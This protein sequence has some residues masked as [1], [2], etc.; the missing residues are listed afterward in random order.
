MDSFAAL[1]PDPLYPEKES[2]RHANKLEA[3][4][5]GVLRWLSRKRRQPLW[6]TR[7]ILAR[8]HR[9]AA[10]LAGLDLAGVR[11]QA[12]EVAFDLRCHGITPAS[13][14]RAFALVRQAGRLAL[15][16]AHFDVQLLG[17]WAMLQGMVAEM[18]TGEGKTLTATLPAATAALA[19]LPV[20]VITTND[21]LVER[22]AEIMAPLYEA[23]GLSVA[24][25]SMEM[26]PQARRDAYQADIVYCSNK[27]LV[28][29]YLRD[30]IVLDDD[31]DED[32]LR[33]ERLRG[34]DGR[35]RQL[36][37]RGLCFAIVDEADSV[38]VDEARTPLIISGVQE[39]DGSAVTAQAMALAAAMQAPHYR[40]QPAERRAVLTE[41]GREYLRQACAALPAPWSIPFR[42][43]ELI[44]SALTVLHLYKRDEQYIVRDGKVMVVD[45]FTGRVMP[46]RSWGQ[47]VHQMIEH[48]EGLE[49]SDPRATLKSI[50]YQRFF[51]HY[52]LLAG[53]TGTAA[54]IRAELGRVYNLPVVRIPT[55]RK[56]RRLHAPD[57]VHRTMADKWAAVR[58][59]CRELHARG[60]P[61]LIGTRSVAASEE[62]A[63]VLAEARLPAVVLN[64]KQDA[65]EAALIARAGEIGSI[66][67]ATN[68]AGRGTDIPLSEAARAAGGLH[69]ILTERHES[70]RIDRQ[71]EGRSGRQGDPG[72]AEAI[73]SLEDAVLDSVKDSLWARPVGAL[74]AAQGPGWRRLAAHWLRHA[75]ARTE[76]KLARERRQMVAA[77]EELENSLSFSGQGD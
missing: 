54:E 11:A 68:M 5:T 66:M 40:I 20:H 25:V 72:H 36:F 30:L 57:S 53:M 65:D 50:S 2:E 46:D 6:R 48:K 26:S 23:L 28:F 32:R 43:E 42:R 49:L 19:G 59:R 34:A 8:V 44:L 15:G 47:G 10:R 12:D 51:K 41:A 60:V 17:G 39:E 9:E 64:A 73:L 29:D 56:S 4:G 18:N 24:W 74:L 76:R 38:L 52:L 63:R 35:L 61:V 14:A 62:V 71:L 21:Y 13:A 67:I 37:L 58:E 45:E 70:A 75:Q 69:V 1:S 7:R 16:K 22:D 27:T 55:H 31:R 33:L 77:D 3:W